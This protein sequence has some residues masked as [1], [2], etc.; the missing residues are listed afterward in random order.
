M[1][2]KAINFLRL[3]LGFFFICTIASATGR[4]YYFDIRSSAIKSLGD[5]SDVS[6]TAISGSYGIVVKYNHLTGLY[7]ALQDSF[8]IAGGVDSLVVD[9]L[10]IGMLNADS[11]T[12]GMVRA[13]TLDAATIMEA[14]VADWADSTDITDDG[15]GNEDLGP[16]IVTTTEIRDGTIAAVD[17]G[18]AELAALAGIMSAADRLPYF[19]GSGTANFTYLS[20]F[21]RGI[22]GDD[23]DSAVR[24]TL[25]LDAL[26]LLAAVDSSTVTDDGIGNE[27]I[28]PNTVTTVEIRDLTIA[29]GDLSATAVDSSKVAAKALS[30]DDISTWNASY[31]YVIKWDPATSAWSAQVDSFAV[32]AGGAYIDSTNITNDSIGEEDLGPNVVTTTAIR[33]GTIALVD[34]ADAAT[35]IDDNDLVEVDGADIADDEYA[36]FTSTG[37]ESRTAAEVAQDIDGSISNAGSLVETGTVAT[38]TWASNITL[39][40]GESIHLAPPSGLSDGEFVGMTTTLESG[41]DTSA[42]ADVVYFDGGTTE[43]YLADHDTEAESG[44]VPIYLALEAKGDGV[45]CIVLIEGWIREDDWDLAAGATVYIGNTGNPTTTVGDIGSGEWIRAIGHSYDA[46]TIYFNPD[47]VWGEAP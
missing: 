44:P 30:L 13:N 27:D 1:K 19:T 37:L 35:G 11:M 25:G 2:Q 32:I 26:A 41:Y 46:D 12:G 7:E 5:L 14:G 18:D 36:R 6:S 24:A 40:I 20:S 16:N 28:G 33:D 23:T 38:G 29:K 4:I 9:E 31:G 22:L 39:G 34:I 17:I 45:S 8:G 43:F 3:L 21:A 15:I 47:A 10:T 42:F